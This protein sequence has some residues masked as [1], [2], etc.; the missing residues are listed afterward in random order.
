MLAVLCDHM[1]SENYES[2]PCAVRFT[3]GF[4]LRGGGGGGGRRIVGGG[5]GGGRL[6]VGSGGG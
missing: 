1:S 3:E 5:G 4:E 6:L 2:D